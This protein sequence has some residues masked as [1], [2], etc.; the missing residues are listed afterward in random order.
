MGRAEAER[1]KEV[2]IGFLINGQKVVLDVTMTA[3]DPV[4]RGPSI[5]WPQYCVATVATSGWRSLST[6]DPK[7]RPQ[8]ID[9]YRPFFALVV[10]FEWGGPINRPHSGRP[11]IILWN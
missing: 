3:I 6:T 11:P 7:I 1:D 4:V 10:A 5:A 2:I 9:L 8:E